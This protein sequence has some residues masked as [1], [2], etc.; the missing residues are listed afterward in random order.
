MNELKKFFVVAMGLSMTMAL[1][2]CDVEEE[3]DEAGVCTTPDGGAGGEGGSAGEGGGAG[4]GGAGGGG[5]TF[6][7]VLIIDDST[8]ENMNGTPGADICG[9]SSSCGNA[10]AAVLNP[11]DGELCDSVRE[12]CSANRADA[13]AAQDDGSSCEADSDPSDYVSLGMGGT[14]SVQFSADQSGC[15]IDVVELVGN[16]DEGYEIYVCAGADASSDCLNNGAAVGGAANG[17]SVS[18]Q[19]P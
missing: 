11:G 10:I 4:E 17:G 8:E 7:N 13:S 14:L 2:A 12:G 19:V 9:V 15:T 1:T 3:C 5:L 16:Q 6:T 18:V